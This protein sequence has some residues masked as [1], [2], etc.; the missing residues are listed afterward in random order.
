MEYNW[1]LSRQQCQ[2][3]AHTTDKIHSS[4]YMILHNIRLETKLSIGFHRDFRGHFDYERT[5]QYKTL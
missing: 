5:T 2:N 4:L 3:D 1:S